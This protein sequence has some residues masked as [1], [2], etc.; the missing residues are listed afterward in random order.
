[1]IRDLDD[2]FSIL[3]RFGITMEQFMLPY[4]LYL[5]QREHGEDPLPRGGEVI[6]YIYRYVENINAWPQD[7]IEMM[8]E[9][10]LI[11]DF[12]TEDAVYPDNLEVTDKFA[13]EVF[14]TKS[15]FERFWETYP[16]FCENFDD[17]RKDKIP[18]KASVK[19]EVKEMFYDHVHTQRDFQNLMEALK[20]A[21]RGDKLKMNIEKFVGS[22]YWKQIEELM[23][24]GPEPEVRIV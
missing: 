3:E 12:N 13:E 19:E 18:L 17:P 5:D 9:K 24:E 16:A 14:A 6:A 2:L 15:D 22:E 1:M 4:I 23:D 10:G 21:K 20:W 11:K 8:V 7:D